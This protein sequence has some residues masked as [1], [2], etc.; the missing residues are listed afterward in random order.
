MRNEEE[1]RILHA[2]VE[3]IVV[4][5]GGDQPSFPVAGKGVEG[6]VSEPLVDIE[7]L[8]DLLQVGFLRGIVQGIGQGDEV[9]P[10]ILA[11][12]GLLEVGVAVAIRVGPLVAEIPLLVGILIV[13]HLVEVAVR[14][15]GP[16]IFGVGAAEALQPCIRTVHVGSAPGEILTVDPQQSGGGI[17]G[18]HPAMS[19]VPAPKDLGMGIPGIELDGRLAV[20]VF[21]AAKLDEEIVGGGIAGTGPAVTDTGEVAQGEACAVLDDEGAVHFR[22][23]VLLVPG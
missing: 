17:G 14:V 6:E 9:T 18:F 19:E 8:T 7:D 4:S 3:S 2:A 12:V 23:A 13:P 10:V 1:A 20:P 11:L 22:V 16:V 15:Q 21:I 5:L